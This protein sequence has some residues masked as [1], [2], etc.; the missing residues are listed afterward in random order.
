MSELN[1]E[2]LKKSIASN[3]IKNLYLLQGESELVNYF[4]KEI[5]SKTLG[6]KYTDFDLTIINEEAFSN[7]SLSI[8]LD[9]F[10]MTTERKCVV[11]KDIPW[12]IIT[13]DDIKV[14]LDIISDIPDFSTL[15]IIQLSPITGVKHTNKFSKVRNYVKKYGVLCN[16]SQEDITLEKQLITWANKE[17]NKK[18]DI[19]N[20]KKIISLCKGYQIHEIKNELKK[21]CEFEKSSEINEKSLEIV[22]KSKPKISIFDLP[23]ALFSNDAKKCFEIIELLFEQREEPIYIVNILASEYIDICRTKLLLEKSVEPMELTKIFDYKNKEF[24][25]KNAY[26]RGQKLSMKSIKDSIKLLIEADIKLKSTS[27]EPK[28]IITEAVILLLNK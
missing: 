22:W 10:P 4:E 6:N 18:L 11:V 2:K 27:I 12:E 8:S 21:I 7:D 28:S 14:L 25:I 23:K 9:T 26:R 13:D 1:Y 3:D 15:L 16:F 19:S 20:A 17:Y 5:T 24:R